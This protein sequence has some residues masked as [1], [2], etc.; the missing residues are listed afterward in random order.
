MNSSG[1][2]TN[3]SVQELEKAV[4]AAT[5]NNTVEQTTPVEPMDC[6]EAP[7]TGPLDTAEDS[8]IREVKEELARHRLD[9]AE[10][11]AEIK[12][13]L[14]NPLPP[15]DKQ[16]YDLQNGRLTSL[17]CLVKTS[18]ESSFECSRL[19][20]L[21]QEV[22]VQPS[23]ATTVK[24]NTSKEDSLEAYKVK[25]ADLPLFKV[26]ESRQDSENCSKFGKESTC[27]IANDESSVII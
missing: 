4:A 23:A 18:Y 3:P 22:T 9:R 25:E 27:L 8:E 21:L 6:D 17:Q 5:I 24:D 10:A 16:A 13:I 11:Q 26:S 1:N 7:S 12:A 15:S 2:S 20:K 19:L 14:Q